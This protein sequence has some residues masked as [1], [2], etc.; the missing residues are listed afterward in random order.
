M[1]ITGVTINNFRCYEATSVKFVY[2]DAN[3]ADPKPK[4]P[5]ITLLLGNNG[6]GKSAILKACVLGTLNRSLPSSGFRPY[7]LVRRT[8]GADIPNANASI[9][10]DLVLHWQDSYPTPPSG[11][12][13]EQ[14]S[15]AVGQ[16]IIQR[17]VSQESVVSTAQVNDPLWQG[18][19]DD[20]SPA[21]FIVAYGA[22]RRV[23][24]SDFNPSTRDKSRSVRYQRVASLFEEYYELIP[25][26]TCI[27]T[28]AQ[29]NRLEEFE[30]IVAK[31]LPDDVKFQAA[32]VD[33]NF[34][35]R[36]TTLPFGAL[37][38]GYRE[39]I[40][41]I[42]DLCYHLMQAAPVGT[43]LYDV[44]G[45]V[46]IDEI[47]LFLHPEWQRV[48]LSSVTSAFPNLQF[49]CSSHSPILAGSVE[50]VNTLI[51]QVDPVQNATTV[52]QPNA[53]IY[54]LSADQIL[55]SAYFGLATTRAP[56]AEE[57]LDEIAKRAWAG[58]DSAAL[59]YLQRLAHGFEPTSQK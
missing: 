49:I 32:A 1:Y 28:A 9:D 43:P 44:R 38:D 55:T 58:D 21:F 29:T 57:G 53:S 36:G 59:E 34:V 8:S 14:P 51:T 12:E 54:G 52:I 33:V 26:A 4:F 31:L 23:E 20:K 6:T 15:H 10:V 46:L 56:G 50:S 25:A 19:F 37:S 41:W 5:N 47:D 39:F 22:N 3:K 40:G 7:Y 48:V 27:Q 30:N 13:F 17:T 18:L 11:W 24:Q 45:V 16:T 2:P 42:F 35:V